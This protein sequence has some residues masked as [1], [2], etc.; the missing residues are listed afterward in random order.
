[1]RTER[2]NLETL[3]AGFERP[4]NWRRDADGVKWP[5]VGNLAI[6]VDP[7]ASG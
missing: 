5:Q 1:M 7:T 2:Q 3:G 4:R 6:Q